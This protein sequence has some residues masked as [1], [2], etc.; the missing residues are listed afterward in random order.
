MHENQFLCM[1]HLLIVILTNHNKNLF[2]LQQKNDKYLACIGDHEI[3]KKIFGGCR[4][5]NSQKIMQT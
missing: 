3:T 1:G 5:Y 2:Q 4:S